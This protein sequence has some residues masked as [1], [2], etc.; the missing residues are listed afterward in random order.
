MVASKF[1]AVLELDFNPRI[2][3]EGVEGLVHYGQCRAM[4]KLSLRFCDIGDRGAAAIG[5]WIAGGDSRVREIL[6]NGNRIGPPGATA[7]GSGLAQN[8]SIVR[9][10]IGDSLFGYDAAC[11]IALHDGIV[12][13][14]TFQAFNALNTFDSPEGIAEKFFELTKMKPLGECVLSVKM[15]SFMFQNIRYFSLINKKKLRKEERRKREEERLADKE[16]EAELEREKTTAG[17]SA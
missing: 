5:R 15:D 9:L 8:R 10:D 3:D 12:A 2:S 11:M 7:I 6:L 16:A 17:A 13:C 1:L 4:K 14:P